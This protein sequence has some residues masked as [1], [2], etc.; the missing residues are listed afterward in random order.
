[1][2]M[3]KHSHRNTTTTPT[4]SRSRCQRPLPPPYDIATTR[5]TQNALFLFT[6]VTIFVQHSS[7]LVLLLLLPPQLP[8]L[9][10]TF[11]FTT[12]TTT[13]MTPN[14]N[15]L[16]VRQ[17]PASQIPSYHHH[18]PPPPQQQQPQQ[19]KYRT[20]P[21]H[22]WRLIGKYF[23]IEEMED[24]DACTTEVILNP[25]STVTTLE[26]NGPIHLAATGMWKLDKLTGDFIMTLHRTYEAGR[27]SKISTDVGVFTFTTVRKFIGRLYNIGI[28]QG[29][30]G[31]IY[32]VT[33]GLEKDSGLADID[34]TTPVTEL[35]K[36][37]FFEMI[38]T[39]L[40]EDGEVT[41]RGRTQSM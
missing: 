9:Q 23:Q 37:G 4:T 41:L 1:M 11:A 34:D 20:R 25:N 3:M 38:D 39:T 29:I 16:L 12:T 33:S 5:R 2:M 13:T 21:L 28:K 32:D 19:S 30:S 36:V 35:R 14:T 27:D 24:R 40:S 8:N 17:L 22:A 15:T 7:L 31:N 6:I 26:T 18:S 10:P